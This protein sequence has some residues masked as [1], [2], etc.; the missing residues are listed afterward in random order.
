MSR[1]DKKES[2]LEVGPRFS[3]SAESP[4][5]TPEPSLKAKPRHPTISQM[6]KIN[7]REGDALIPKA[8]TFRLLPRK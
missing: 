4:E 3:A 5:A 2:L 7:P 6:R 8:S 1:P